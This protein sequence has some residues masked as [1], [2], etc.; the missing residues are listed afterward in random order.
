MLEQEPLSSNKDANGKS[1]Q[2][3][4]ATPAKSK[5]AHNDLQ[6]VVDD[7]PPW[8]TTIG[9]GLQVPSMQS[10]HCVYVK[11]AH[12]VA[13]TC[14]RTVVTIR[15]LQSYLFLIKIKTPNHAKALRQAATSTFDRKY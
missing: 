12:K 15:L 9:L 5:D 6:Y 11:H 10:M 3:A 14:R 4:K 1:N 7:I 2:Q 13:Y 8:Y